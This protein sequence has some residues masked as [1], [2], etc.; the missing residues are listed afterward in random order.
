MP[1]PPLFSPQRV[2]SGHGSILSA[3]GRAGQRRPSA[4]WGLG[5]GATARGRVPVAGAG[6]RPMDG[7]PMNQEICRASHHREVI[8]AD[9]EELYRE[10]REDW[11]A[12]CVHNRAGCNHKDSMQRAISGCMANVNHIL[13]MLH[14]HDLPYG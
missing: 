8:L 10:D 3:N 12:C 7:L 9:A 11:T 13:T 1:P 6:K 2:G 5:P 4:T 14:D